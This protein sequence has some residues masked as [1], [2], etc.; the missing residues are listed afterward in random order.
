MNILKKS[1]PFF[2]SFVLIELFSP[3]KRQNNY[4]H[5][6]KEENSN[7][8]KLYFAPIR[9]NK[10]LTDDAIPIDG[11]K[12]IPVRDL[13]E[14][15][16]QACRNDK[17]PEYR[18]S[19]LQYN[20]VP[21]KM[22]FSRNDIT[23][24]EWTLTLVG[25]RG[26]LD[27][28]RTVA[29]FYVNGGK[30]ENKVAPYTTF[31]LVEGS[32]FEFRPPPQ[33]RHGKFMRHL[34]FMVV[35][36]DAGADVVDADDGVGEEAQEEVAQEEE[37]EEVVTVPFDEDE[38][39]K[40]VAQEEEEV[41]TVPSD[42]EKEE[43][44]IEELTVKSPNMLIQE[45][46]NLA[47]ESGQVVYLL[48]TPDKI[49]ESEIGTTAKTAVVVDE[50]NENALV[51]PVIDENEDEVPQKDDEENAIVVPSVDVSSFE[52]IR[53]AIGFSPLND[54]TDPVPHDEDLLSW[55]LRN[56]P[57]PRPPPSRRSIYDPIKIN[58]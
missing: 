22:K 7:T 31:K 39:E 2:H 40:N 58:Q 4:N 18:K 42:E 12:E 47:E 24:D 45:R 17:G 6:K 21:S 16:Q 25:F 13:L 53:R 34:K 48:D 35:A 33:F 23:T 57:S 41:V 29:S 51:V 19:L 44:E 36:A 49:K 56:S 37:E 20:N 38:A 32:V 8:M 15:H 5:I 46:H 11:T 43:E 30:T 52:E 55:S 27:D 26:R 1:G 14:C 9:D 28:N 54:T 10:R 3:A 50:E